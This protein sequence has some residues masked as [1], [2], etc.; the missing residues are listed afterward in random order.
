MWEIAAT[1]ASS[2]RFLN[3]FSILVKT[4]QIRLKN[5]SVLQNVILKLSPV[6]ILAFFALI[7]IQLFNQLYFSWSKLMLSHRDIVKPLVY[8]TSVC[9][10]PQ[11]SQPV[12]SSAS[13]GIQFVKLSIQ[14]ENFATEY[15]VHIIVAT[16]KR[17][18]YTQSLIRKSAKC[19]VGSLEMSY[20]Q[21]KNYLNI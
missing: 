6:L 7:S 15:K 14:L 20:V 4:R 8:S 19:T 11:L 3:P 17:A 16:W 18:K 10:F 1:Y 9:L 13:G 5:C 2:F 12:S 21:T